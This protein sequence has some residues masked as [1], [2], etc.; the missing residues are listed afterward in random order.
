MQTQDRRE[1]LF[2]RLCL[3]RAIYDRR[4]PLDSTDVISVATAIRWAEQLMQ[5]PE[6]L[7]RV[8]NPRA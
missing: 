2:E 7:A 5:D 4:G 3:Y 8:V 1:Q 6:L